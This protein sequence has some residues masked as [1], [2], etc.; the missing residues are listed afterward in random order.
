MIKIKDEESTCCRYNASKNK[1]W[2]HFLK[3][4]KFEYLKDITLEDI[5]EFL[6]K[7]TSTWYDWLKTLSLKSLSEAT[8]LR[9]HWNSHQPDVNVET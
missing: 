5:S 8:N 6:D 7:S 9:L 1:C 4:V 2:R 3:D